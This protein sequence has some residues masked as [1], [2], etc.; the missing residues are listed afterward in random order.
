MGDGGQGVSRQSSVETGDDATKEKAEEQS[1][2]A[3]IL[4]R[5]HASGS[6]TNA[7]GENAERSRQS[8]DD[9]S[10]PSNLSTP[11]MSPR[12]RSPVKVSGG[13][14]VVVTLPKKKKKKDSFDGKARAEADILKRIAEL[15]T[16][17]LWTGKKMVR[18]EEDKGKYHWDF[19]LEEM[20]WL[21]AVV[22][23]EIKT[24]KMLA[25]K[26]ASMV[27]KHFKDK[28]MAVLRAE[29]AREANL[30]RI[31]GMMSREVKNFWSNVN[32]LFEYRVKIKLDAKRKEALDQHL[33]F[34]VDKTGKY[35]T[36]LAE[37]MADN[38]P[39]SVTNSGAPSRSESVM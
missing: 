34:I 26:C 31:A 35:S 9:E 11:R 21:A 29:K 10:V 23:Q 7:V 39:T 14:S 27:Q 22:Q 16:Q 4:R 8:T 1:V 33:N 37:S 15:Q 25:K 30:R 28:E 38:A 6:G 18:K 20:V 3:R 36:L 12:S 17:G 5:R 13:E 2:T 24:K 19:V 32:K